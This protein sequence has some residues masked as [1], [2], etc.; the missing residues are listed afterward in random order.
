MFWRKEDALNP[1]PSTPDE[2]PASSSSPGLLDP[3][4]WGPHYWF[5][6][7]SVASTYPD[8]PSSTTKRKY[9]DLVMNMPLFIPVPA[10]GADFAALLDQFPV[11]PYLVNR[12]S[13]MRWTNSIHNH[14][15]LLRGKEPVPFFQ[16]VLLHRNHYAPQPAVRAH[17][18]K[19][20]M[21]R[22]LYLCTILAALAFVAHHSLFAT[23][24]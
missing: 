9:Y 6:M 11:S 20:Y 1:R 24:A 3:D 5:F 2:P 23:T 19:K 12:Q 16:S 21:I 17:L 8:F 13:F 14:Y 10:M 7:H 4:V 15:N 22:L 18:D